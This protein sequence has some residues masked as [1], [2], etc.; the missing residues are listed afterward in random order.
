LK[1]IL[2]IQTAFIGDVILATPLLEALHAE[3]P[4]ARIDML[5]RKGNQ[6]LFQGHPFLKTVFVWD[7]QLGKYKNLLLLL[8]AIRRQKYDLVIN[9]QRFA[10]SGFLTAF[11]GAISTSGFRKNPFSIFFKR[12]ANHTISNGL[13]ECARNLKLIEHLNIT[14]KIQPRLYPAPLKFE[15]PKHY[16]CIA[17]ASV[18]FTKQWPK[19]KWIELINLIPSEQTIYLTGGPGDHALCEEILK[20]TAHPQVI[21]LAGSLSLLE[22]A[23]LMRAATMNYVN[24]SAP[25]H[26]C[27]SVNAPVTAIFCSTVPSFGFG[28]LSE[29]SHIIETKE[30][31]PCRPCGLHGFK[32]CPKGH[33]QCAESIQPEN[34][35]SN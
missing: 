32:A 1:K 23:E 4:E 30:E 7:K 26:L 8:I 14:G 13:H 17:P 28:P 35:L 19:N 11:S 21:N 2:I 31:L 22:S 10:A 24:D 5:V 9:C 27:S 34:V 15:T 33:F 18:W 25:M 29:N 6:T 16:C 3:F 12:K 20:S